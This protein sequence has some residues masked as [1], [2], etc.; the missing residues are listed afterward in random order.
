MSK[1]SPRDRDR[2]DLSRSCECGVRQSAGQPHAQDARLGARQRETLACGTGA[3]AASS[4][5]QKTASVKRAKTSRFV[6][7]GDHLVRYTDEAVFIDRRRRRK[8][9]RRCRTLT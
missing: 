6:S 8:T 4:P 3:C 1:R 5:Q 7:R 2:A 9:S